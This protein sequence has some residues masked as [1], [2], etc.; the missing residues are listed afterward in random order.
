MID[1]VLVV[2][3]HPLVS[4]AIAE[5]MRARFPHVD[6]RSAES[7]M[8][9]RTILAE[10][11]ETH[12]FVLAFVDMRLPDADGLELLQELCARNIP[13]VIITGEADPITISASMRNGAAGFIEK[14]ARIE[15]ILAAAQAV[16][17][18][19]Q[20]FPNNYARATSTH[21]NALTALANL[22][23]KQKRVLDLV[24]EGRAN[25]FI[26]SEI[27]VVEGTVRN[28]VSELFDIFQIAGR[29][30]TQLIKRMHEMR[31]NPSHPGVRFPIH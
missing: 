30:R 10:A 8:E 3:D 5:A 24:L 20:Y 15:T 2:D 16:M 7:A 11:D 19:G 22:T 27:G 14:T 1:V 31:Y 17:A 23:P 9:M 18:G 6:V 21:D 25:K 26:A 29:S 13:V 4:N 12:H 28:T